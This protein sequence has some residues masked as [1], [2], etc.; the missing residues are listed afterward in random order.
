MSKT[1]DHPECPVRSHMDDP[2]I[3]WRTTKPDFT[4]VDQKYLKEKVMSHKE[5]SLAKIVE[6]LV[7]SWECESSHKVDVKDW[8]TVNREKFVI[9]VNGGRKLNLK[10][11]IA[12]GNYLMFLED[13]PLYDTASLT[14]EESQK[15]FKK[16]FPA[17]FAWEVLEVFSGPPKVSF[18]WRHWADY[19]GEFYGNAPTNERIELVGSSVATLDDDMKIC[20]FDIYYDPSPMLNKLYHGKCKFAQQQ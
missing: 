17:G 15:A 10:D 20:T 16:C 18:T 19:E 2:N 12:M 14:N 11:N 7:K 1:I 8:G 4:I 6:N 5:G 3:K 9:T 13:S